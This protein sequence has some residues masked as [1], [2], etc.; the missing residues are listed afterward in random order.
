MDEQLKRLYDHRC[1]VCATRL[2]SKCGP[3]V[4][5]VP[6][7]PE[8]DDKSASNH[9]CLCLNHSFL[10]QNGMIGIEPNLDLWGLEGTLQ[11]NPPHTISQGALKAHKERALSS[12]KPQA[13]SETA[14]A[15][16]G[17]DS[18]ELYNVFMLL[19][20]AVEKN[21]CNAIT[22][23]AATAETLLKRAPVRAQKS[24]KV[25]RVMGRVKDMDNIPKVFKVFQE[26][27]Q[28]LGMRVS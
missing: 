12:A 6:I 21:D 26:E 19:S 2:T 3:H 13:L 22:E 8:S 16:L 23:L 15:E 28:G 17:L 14:I 24:A 10:F 25:L 18:T 9:I 27:L 5:V 4:E 1:Q 20:N 11:V 7:D